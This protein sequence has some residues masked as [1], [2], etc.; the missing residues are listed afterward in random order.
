MEERG[1]PTEMEWQ[2][3]GADCGVFGT[4]NQS[5]VENGWVSKTAICQVAL[6]LTIHH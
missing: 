2:G 3:G 4:S 1:D 6:E 5:S